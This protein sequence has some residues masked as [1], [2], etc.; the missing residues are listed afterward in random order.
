MILFFIALALLVIFGLYL[1]VPIAR[2]LTLGD[3]LMVK[4]RAYIQTPEN[5]TMSI[6]VMGDSTAV[7]TGAAYGHSTAGYLGKE[8]PMAT[9]LTDA[10]NGMKIEECVERLLK[11]KH[12]QHDLALFQIGA[13]DVTGLTSFTNIEER[14]QT[15]LTLSDGVAK[16]TIILSA[17][18]VGTV[19]IFRWPLSSLM[20]HRSK[21]MRLLYKRLIAGHPKAVYVDLSGDGIDE[22]FSYD[23]EKFYAADGFHP[24]GEG[25]RQWFL[26]IR[27]N[28]RDIAPEKPAQ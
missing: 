20:S 19:P 25:Y 26:E 28:I 4:S 24:S 3:S 5:P 8:F 15:I 16:Q 27:K 21:K 18:D 1:Y 10:K 2:A 17:G 11:R 13:N 6:L 23:S 7:G 12:E 14:L 22:V 9:V